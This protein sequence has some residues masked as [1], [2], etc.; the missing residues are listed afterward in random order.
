MMGGSSMVAVQRSSAY[1]QFS[2]AKNTEN[3]GQNVKAPSLVKENKKTFWT[4]KRV[5]ATVAVAS[6]ALIGS[7]LACLALNKSSSDKCQPLTDHP[8]LANNLKTAIKEA[9][10]LN[11]QSAS[12]AIAEIDNFLTQGLKGHGNTRDKL[13]ATISHPP[14][15]KPDFR[16]YANPKCL[17]EK[18]RLLTKEAVFEITLGKSP[19]KCS[20]LTPN[21]ESYYSRCEVDYQIYIDKA[22]KSLQQHCD[23]STS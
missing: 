11:G 5:A 21:D 17:T 2:P 23:Q 4:N 7:G 18:S 22:T 10:A 14:G 13:L 1:P 6:V 12:V 20:E 19:L 8:A 15:A 3:T 16:L 9:C